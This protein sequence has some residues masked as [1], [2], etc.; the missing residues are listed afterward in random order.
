MIGRNLKGSMFLIL[1]EG[2][3]RTFHFLVFCISTW[4]VCM[5]KW[6]QEQ[7]ISLTSVVLTNQLLSLMHL[8]WKFN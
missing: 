7:F 4:E 5:W 3:L 2:S 8:S 1:L 6:N